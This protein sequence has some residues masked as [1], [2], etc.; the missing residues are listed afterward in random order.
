MPHI[1]TLADFSLKYVI[2]A[3]LPTALLWWKQ[4]FW[5]KAFVSL[6]AFCVTAYTI[7]LAGTFMCDEGSPTLYLMILFGIMAASLPWVLGKW[8]LAVP[9]ALAGVVLAGVYSADTLDSYMKPGP[10][11][12]GTWKMP[13][14]GYAGYTLSLTSSGDYELWTWSDCINVNEIEEEPKKGKYV[15]DQGWLSIPVK[16]NYKD[17]HS[18]SFTDRF[19]RETIN[20][21]E[22]L[23]RDWN[24][25]GMIV[26][27]DLLVKVSDHPNYLTTNDTGINRLFCNTAARW[28]F[29]LT[30]KYPITKRL[31]P[32]GC[33][34]VN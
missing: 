14:N 31:F 1:L 21:V 34:Q 24:R 5:T 20:G 9:C 29:K 2:I 11:I 7:L 33:D 25:R 13:E 27:Y 6:V 17:G 4:T 32:I 22:V 3:I 18:Y 19:K 26:A 23:S 16:Q 10:G 30:K 12:E 15:F 8:R 28:T